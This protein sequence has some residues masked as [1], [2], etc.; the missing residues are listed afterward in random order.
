MYMLFSVLASFLSGSRRDEEGSG[1]GAYLDAGVA[2]EVLELDAHQAAH[3]ASTRLGR[4]ACRSNGGKTSC[5]SRPGVKVWAVGSPGLFS[6]HLPCQRM[7]ST[8]AS[9]W[10]IMYQLCPHRHHC[11]GIQHERNGVE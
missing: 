4:I 7:R 2:L 10:Y 1:E 11:R 6:R 5:L 9:S 8:G 3:D